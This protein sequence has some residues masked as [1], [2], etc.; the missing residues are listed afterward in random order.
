[1]L[2]NSEL[3][4]SKNRLILSNRAVSEMFKLQKALKCIDTQNSHLVV[5]H[6]NRAVITLKFFMTMLRIVSNLGA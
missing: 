2:Q 5:K 4:S 6:S 3:N 1:M